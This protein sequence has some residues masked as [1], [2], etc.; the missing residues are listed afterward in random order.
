MLYCEQIEISDNER[1]AK[2]HETV[3]L[4]SFFIWV[5]SIMEVEVKHMQYMSREER[6]LPVTSVRNTRDLG[7]YETQSGAYTKSHK[8]VRCAGMDNLTEVDRQYLIDYGM[9]AVIDLRSAAERQKE[10]NVLLDDDIIKY[11]SIDLFGGGDAVL[12]PQ[13][14]D[15]KDMGDLYCILLD[16]AQPAIKE[17]FK[18]F[19]Q[20]PYDGVI[21]H[22]S[23]GKDRT[24]VI[25]ALLLDLAGCHEYD[26]VKDY[27]ESYENN[28]EINEK[29]EKML[30][31]GQVRYLYSE[32]LY[33]MKMLNHLR[34]HYGSSQEYLVKIGLTNEEI[35][36]LK[37]N[38]TF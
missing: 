31:P 11:Y 17:V 3:I 38:F 33:M 13:N 23:A 20:Y 24:G 34:D 28:M 15:F 22:C 14:M 26:I 4:S 5:Y 2:G 30:E 25:A 6:L 1:Q 32:P 18:T 35:D 29:L 8:Y 10:P 27:S 37:E 7:G 12:V 16:Q 21:F 9:R 19:L 36:E